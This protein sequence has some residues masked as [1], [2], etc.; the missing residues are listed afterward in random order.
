[1]T[2]LISVIAI[3]VPSIVALASLLAQAAHHRAQQRTERT[4]LFYQDRV[5]ALGKMIQSVSSMLR[6]AEAALEYKEKL[7]MSFRELWENTNGRIPKDLHD[8]FRNNVLSGTALGQ[9]AIRAELDKNR[10]F[11]PQSVASVLQ[12]FDDE[13]LSSIPDPLHPETIDTFIE[14]HLPAM[15]RYR[16][17]LIEASQEF[18]MLRNN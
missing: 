12:Q 5:E 1:M 13:M 15:K 4:K 8:G 18:M 3:V 14:A 10:L 2:T 17:S 6:N 11:L 7:G 16:D 9:S